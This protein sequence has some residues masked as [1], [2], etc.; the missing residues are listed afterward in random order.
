MAA[1]KNFRRALF[2]LFGVGRGPGL[3]PSD[4]V[5]DPDTPAV[6]P[7]FEQESPVF[8]GSNGSVSHAV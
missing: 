1:K 7:V 4:C 2:E 3:S 6:G 5:P 8:I